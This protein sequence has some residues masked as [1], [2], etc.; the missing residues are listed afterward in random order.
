MRACARILLEKTQ[1]FDNPVVEINEFGFTQS[2]DI[3]ICHV[4]TA[5]VVEQWGRHTDRRSPVGRSSRK[6]GIAS[7]SASTSCSDLPRPSGGTR[8]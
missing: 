5:H 4:V 8:R 6:T 2:V 1:A 7:I 3:D